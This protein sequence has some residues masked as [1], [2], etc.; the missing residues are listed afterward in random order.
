LLSFGSD[1]KFWACEKVEKRERDAGGASLTAQFPKH[2]N[3][4]A[5]P[6]MV[7]FEFEKSGIGGD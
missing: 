2:T 6:H 7:G 1:W 4:E 3:A 5:S